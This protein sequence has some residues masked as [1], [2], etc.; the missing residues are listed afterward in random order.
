M[1]LPIGDAPNPDRVAWA[2]WLLILANVAVFVLVTLPL[3]TTP[4]TASELAQFLSVFRGVPP[5]GV[6]AYDVFVLA[7]GFRTAEPA[8]AD[9]GW[10]LFLH[11]GLAH[12]GSNLLFLWIYGD[13]V[14]ARLGS[15]P[16]LL[17]Y[18]VAGVAATAFYWL[19]AGATDVPLI[20]ASGA[21]SGVLGAYLVWFPHNR[22]KLLVAA[23]PFFVDVVLVPAWI[24]LSAFLLLDNVVPLFLGAGT[25]VAYGAHI[26]GFLFGLALALVLRR[27]V[28]RDGDPWR[29]HLEEGLRAL[30][31]GD[32]PSAYTYLMQA[33]R[34]GDAATSEAAR[35]A[36]LRI[37][38]PR[39]QA[40]L[41]G[42][43]K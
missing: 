12:I 38:D 17:F 37:P 27:R 16:Y 23:F 10:S 2:N 8:L 19:L 39:L 32:W 26:G 28:A 11:S 36:L 1:I 14:E 21:I 22:V 20:G 31:R 43:R 15:L 35:R 40:W 3:S 29:A 25:G 6:S 9:L 7:H 42:R 13:N 41:H 18:G 33:W 4:A 34:R 5:D 24:V 30:D